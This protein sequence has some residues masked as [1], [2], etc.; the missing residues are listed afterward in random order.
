MFELKHITLSSSGGKKI[1]GI[2]SA[3][4]N[5]KGWVLLLHMMPSVKESWDDLSRLLNAEGITTLAIDLAGHGESS[6][7]PEGYLSFS[8]NEHQ[9]NIN[10]VKKALE[11]LRSGGAEFEKTAIIGASIGANLALKYTSEYQNLKTLILLSAGLN[12]HGIKTEP[13]IEK[14]KS[15]SSILFVS[16]R[17]DER[18]NSDNAEETQKLFNLVPADVEKEI[19]VYEHAGH[20]TDMLKTDEMPSLPETIV[21]F[22]KNIF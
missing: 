7:G 13:F 11:F 3:P 9:D 14:I 2:F 5:I 10:D 1:A 21:N 22:L 6:G 20:G 12:Y 16:S 8:D 4:E 19:I 18:K 15:G 17:D